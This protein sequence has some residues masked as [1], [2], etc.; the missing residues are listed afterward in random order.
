MAAAA[1]SPE[2]MT[3]L[4]CTSRR[5]HPRGARRAG[6]ALALAL[7]AGCGGGGNGGPIGA[8]PD[9]RYD[10]AAALA[11]LLTTTRSWTVS[12]RGSDGRDYTMTLSVAPGARAAYPMSAFGVVG[13]TSVQRA[14]LRTAG[15]DPIASTT[16]A[17]VPDAVA[18]PEGFSDDSGGCSTV[19][20]GRTPSTSAAVGSGE[21]MLSTLDFDG[22]TRDV[23]IVVAQTEVRWSLEA[24]S[25][26][27]YFCLTT[28][29]FEEPGRVPDGSSDAT[30]FEVDA[31]GRLGNRAIV[32]VNAPGFT[33]ELRG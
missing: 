29:Y 26:V 2:Q 27:P 14:E 9:A 3:H 28:T 33:L 24:V 32:R 5:H 17:Y 21:L 12:G 1:R 31:Q 15:F 30:C 11:Q 23:S 18:L 7:L 22:C 4:P 20:A 19:S 10:A 16:V 8:P 13:R 25:G 6:L